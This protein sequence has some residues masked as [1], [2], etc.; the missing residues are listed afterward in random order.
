M[1]YETT[2]IL[3]LF[4]NS[5]N[6]NKNFDIMGLLATSDEAVKVLT[7]Y[8]KSKDWPCFACFRLNLFEKPQMI[9]NIVKLHVLQ[10]FN[11]IKTISKRIENLEVY[12]NHLEG[13]L[14]SL[15]FIEDE[16]NLIRKHAEPK[17]PKSENEK[18]LDKEKEKEREA[19]KKAYQ[20]RKA[21]QI[22]QTKKKADE[23]RMYFYI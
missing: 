11:N 7:Q 15:K 21:L 10:I 19:K 16:E 17:K 4:F 6:K 8:I 22:E 18:K 5:N 1:W 3:E 2:H 20:E 12:K 14:N 9:D 13:V 23:D